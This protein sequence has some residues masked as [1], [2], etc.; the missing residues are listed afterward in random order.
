M[1]SF[2]IYHLLMLTAALAIIACVIGQ[3]MQGSKTADVITFA[4]GVVFLVVCGA[5][6]VAVIFAAAIALVAGI[7]VVARKGGAFA[8]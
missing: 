8:R 3:L 5:V 4:V 7:F 6:A 2:T 1:P